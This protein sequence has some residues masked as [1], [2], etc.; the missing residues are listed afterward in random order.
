MSLFPISKY[1]RYPNP[2]KLDFLFSQPLFLIMNK[3]IGT[4]NCNKIDRP[5]KISKKISYLSVFWVKRNY[6][7]KSM[8][9]F[10]FSKSEKYKAFFCGHMVDIDWLL[11]K[12]T[13]TSEEFFTD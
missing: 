10:F 8:P 9:R 12:L 1:F 2:V 3:I 4:F 7:L 11:I 6:I 5:D 13:W